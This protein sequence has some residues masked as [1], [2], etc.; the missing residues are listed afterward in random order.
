MANSPTDYELLERWRGGDREAGDR[1]VRRHFRPVF[2]FF[3]HKLDVEAEDLSQRTFEA[4]ANAR[5]RIDPSR[6]FRAYL[7]GIARNQLL[8]FLR[9]GGRADAKHAEYSKVPLGSVVT[10][11]GAVAINEEQLLLAR[12]LRELPLDSQIALE[13]FYWEEMSTADIGAVLGEPVGT[14][15]S[16]LARARTVLRTRIVELARSETLAASTL[17]GL[18]RWAQS[19]RDV[20]FTASESGP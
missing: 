16:R 10:P 13:L 7:L 8:M 6:S 19:L 15:K 17:G 14:I 1:L 9:A 2:R 5:G 18:D 3:A 4:C 12:A 20:V 11:S